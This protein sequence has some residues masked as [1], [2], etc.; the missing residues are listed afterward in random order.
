[1]PNPEIAAVIRA[2]MTETPDFPQ[3]GILFRDLSGLFAS[4]S[5][6]R[7]VAEA[8]IDDFGPI[9]AVVGVE[10]RGF[11]L[12]AAAAVAGGVGMLAVRK[13]GKLPGEVLGESYEL[14]YGTATLEV[15]PDTLPR[16]ARVVIVDDVLATGGTL[17][18][19]LRLMDGAGWE[20]AGIA[21]VIE[22]EALGGRAV[23]ADATSAPVRALLEL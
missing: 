6:L 20:V 16:G 21:V 11:V 15:H 10:A 2:G 9:D 22:L 18:A 4:A 8:L 19:T 12:G 3:P 23:L 17:A 5:S 1:M 14:E 13:A 7:A